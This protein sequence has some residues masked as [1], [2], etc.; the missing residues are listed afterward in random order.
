MLED[1][2]PKYKPSIGLLAGM[3]FGCAAWYWVMG[4]LA[5]GILEPVF[6][7]LLAYLG[8]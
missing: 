4:W 2:G 8:F 3:L 1:K 7:S 6:S 5:W